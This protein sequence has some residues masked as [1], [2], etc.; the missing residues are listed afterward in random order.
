MEYDEHELR[1]Y[2]IAMGILIVIVFGLRV[3]WA[4]LIYG[5]MRC[6]FAECRIQ[7]NP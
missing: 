4:K 7:V 6:T 1:N 5:D 3:L 2:L